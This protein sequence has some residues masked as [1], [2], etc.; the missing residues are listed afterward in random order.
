M[1]KTKHNGALTVLV[2][3]APS[4]SCG[5]HRAPLQKT[6]ENCTLFGRDPFWRRRVE[7][8]GR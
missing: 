7:S 2:I 3:R 1:T 5:A 6:N 4:L 8:R